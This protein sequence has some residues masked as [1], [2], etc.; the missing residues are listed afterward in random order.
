MEL[1][2]LSI[3]PSRFCSKACSFCY[4]GSSRAG[5]QGFSAAEVVELA[6][7]C[8]RHGVRYLSIGGGE[9]LE[10]PGL[11]DA[12]AGLRGVVGR[13][14]TSNGLPFVARP[15]LYERCAEASPDNIHLSIHSPELT[16]EVDRVISQVLRLWSLGLKAGVNLL[17]RR[18]QQP[19]ARHAVQRMV[20]AG[21]TAEQ[22]M[23]L[24]VRGVGADTPSPRELAE[25]A[26]PFPRF[27]SMS[28]LAKCGK[29]ERFASIGADRSVAW[30]S[31]TIARRP[32]R[33][34][35]YDAIVAALD[36][37]ELLPCSH[38]MVGDAPARPPFLKSRGDVAG[39]SSSR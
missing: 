12:L 1:D 32:L 33:A 21:F 30:C 6:T 17:V 26:A 23:L 34:L 38:A 3:E 37:L 24:P 10:W 19:A 9:P 8:A 36:G 35:T 22:V 18:A 28:C 31:Y 16:P 2:R 11:F 27:Q 15:E 20:D 5:G 14:F 7:D 13:S 39:P 25:V 4:N 29:S